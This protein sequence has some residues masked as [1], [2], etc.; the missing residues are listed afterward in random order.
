M[1]CYQLS[2]LGNGTCA[3]NSVET[4]Y[5]AL[6]TLSILKSQKKTKYCLIETMMQKVYGCTNFDLSHCYF[7]RI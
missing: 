6:D 5:G 7:Q 4:L 2:I 1:L 3:T